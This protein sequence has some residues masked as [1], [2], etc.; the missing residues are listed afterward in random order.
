MCSARDG[1]IRE[2]RRGLLKSHGEVREALGC[3][4]EGAGGIGACARQQAGRGGVDGAVVPARWCASLAGWWGGI[5]CGDCDRSRGRCRCWRQRFDPPLGLHKLGQSP[6][7]CHGAGSRS[8]LDRRSRRSRGTTIRN[9]GC[10]LAPP[11]ISD[12]AADRQKAGE[13]YPAGCCDDDYRDGGFAGKRPPRLPRLPRLA[14]RS[15]RRGE[16]CKGR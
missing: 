1:A 10:M 9:D 4:L 3:C 7:L 13:S 11:S 6:S 2:G 16:I 15:V 12:E 8:R 5:L 14:L